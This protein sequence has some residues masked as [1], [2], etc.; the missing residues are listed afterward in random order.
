MQAHAFVF[1]ILLDDLCIN[2]KGFELLVEICNGMI[3]L[4]AF[5]HVVASRWMFWNMLE[6]D[7]F[8]I[9]V[10]HGQFVVLYMQENDVCSRL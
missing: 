10:I 1:E 6:A 7:A 4:L 3:T 2:A 5:C 8:V 9:I